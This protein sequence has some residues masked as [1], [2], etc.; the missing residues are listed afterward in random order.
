LDEATTPVASRIGPD[1]DSFTGAATQQFDRRSAPEPEGKR[2]K[3]S[4]S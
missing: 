2:W 1:T 3:G 4:V